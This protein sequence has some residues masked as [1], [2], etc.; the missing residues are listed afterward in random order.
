MVFILFFITSRSII[1]F[2]SYSQ[3]NNDS[4]KS[5][6]QV[7]SRNSDCF[8]NQII[9]SRISDQNVQICFYNCSFTSFNG[10]TDNS[11]KINGYIISLSSAISKFDLCCFFDNSINSAQQSLVYLNSS[12]SDFSNCNFS[13]NSINISVDYR[14]FLIHSISSNF[15]VN[16][17]T[18]TNNYAYSDKA[19]IDFDIYG[20]LIYIENSN[21]LINFSSFIENA[22]YI[23]TENDKHFHVDINGGLI[24]SFKS[25][26][27]FIECYFINNT[28][29]VN[30]IHGF[31]LVGGLI[32][33]LSSNGSIKSCISAGNILT[34]NIGGDY[35]IIGGLVYS[36]KSNYTFSFCVFKT[37]NI[38]MN[39]ISEP[40]HYIQGGLIHLYESYNDFIEC[41][42]QNNIMFIN[43]SYHIT[44]ILGGSILSRSSKC[45]ISKCLFL[46]N[47]IYITSYDHKYF[48]GSVYLDNSFFIFSFCTFSN[49]NYT[50]IGYRSYN[51][52]GGLLY[53]SYS[54]CDLIGCSY[55]DNYL[56]GS[57]ISLYSSNGTINE[58]SFANN[59]FT[60]W[61]DLLIEGRSLYLSLSNYT[62]Y[63]TNFVNN[64]ILFINNIDYQGE[65]YLYISNVTFKFCI[66]DDN[67]DSLLNLSSVHGLYVYLSYSI[68]TFDN[69][70]F[71]SNQLK[72]INEQNFV[73]NGII[74][75]NFLSSSSKTTFI[76]CLEIK[77]CLFEINY[78]PNI[79]INS[80]IYSSENKNASSINHF[81]NNLINIFH[82][83][84][85]FDVFGGNYENATRK[86]YFSDNCLHPFDDLFFKKDDITLYDK[87]GERQVTF[88]D[89]FNQKCSVPT[90][91]FTSSYVFSNSIE[92][93]ETDYLTQ[94]FQFSNSFD[95]SNSAK[96]TG[97]FL[98]SKSEKFTESLIFSKTNHFSHSNDFSESNVFSQSFDFTKTNGFTKSKFFSES[99][100]FSK[101]DFLTCSNHFSHSN[102]FSE[103]NVFSQSFDFTKTNGFTK[104]KFFS[105]SNYFSKTEFLTCS[106]HF[107]QSDSFEK[108]SFF[109]KSFEFTN[110]NFF[111]K[112]E[113]FIQT[114]LFSK[115]SKFSESNSFS[116]SEKPFDIPTQISID[117]KVLISSSFSLTCTLI[118]SVI[119]SYSYDARKNTYSYFP[120]IIYSLS[121]SYVP[122]YY[123]LYIS[124]NKRISPE[125]LIGIVCGSGAVF[126][127][128]L[129]IIIIIVRKKNEYRI[130][131][132]EKDWSFSSSSSMNTNETNTQ[133]KQF[134]TDTT[135][136]AKL[137]NLDEF[138]D[139]L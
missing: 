67:I 72:N 100:Y 48:R 139:W 4:L 83:N 17:C 3:N 45:S 69:C 91:I 101:T 36:E 136:E 93:S 110:T 62:I 6:Y 11:T 34:S 131:L 102:D 57:S 87:T 59:V 88:N 26:C 35:Y 71:N 96:F 39:Q 54:H 74:H 94:S 58:C 104:S 133:T 32:H 77:N 40:F 41:S 7:E 38:T 130:Y 5:Q 33:L 84:L 56:Y 76:P 61:N 103:S 51:H 135:I 65:I 124:S 99:N 13:N 55:L 109:S 128:I 106:K 111:T 50:F 134:V 37:N 117:Q 10:L 81:T 53:V 90:F 43:V 1:D 29:V 75:F 27:D 44:D 97:T 113:E 120:Y 132:E 8:K 92:F 85:D 23:Y 138:D 125:N 105:E 64:S 70:V 121:P 63:R 79:K 73:I 15:S 20:G 24:A 89:V 123:V 107:S 114:T 42:F 122:T 19:E 78:Y 95:F 112:S 82:P 119:F 25:H 98:F 2:S 80:I 18:F 127:S 28:F 129:S 60:I 68:G 66:F 137:T 16:N 116:Q 126:F 118:K 47:N 49:N 115:S 31:R 12:F 86:W 46:K 108:S 22:I 14:G 9:S 52:D 21:S 30:I